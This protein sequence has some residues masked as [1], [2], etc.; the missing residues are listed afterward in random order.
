VQ[1]VG[2]QVQVKHTKTDSPVWWFG[3][4]RSKWTNAE[5]LARWWVVGGG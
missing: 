3:L 4:H 5:S 2:A 1:F